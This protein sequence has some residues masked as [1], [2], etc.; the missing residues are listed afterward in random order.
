[1]S[2]RKPMCAD[3]WAI[4]PTPLMLSHGNDYHTCSA[5]GEKADAPDKDVSSVS[6]LGRPDSPIIPTIDSILDELMQYS[7]DYGAKKIPM[8]ENPPIIKARQAKAQL[9][10]I[11]A[12]ERQT[13]MKQAKSRVLRRTE[14]PKDAKNPTRDIVV[15]TGEE[16]ARIIQQDIDALQTLIEE[17]PS[18]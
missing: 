14:I 17:T 13:G 3:A 16:C 10:R 18:E 2:K 4:P 12:I 11:Y 5:C 9:Q 15:I 6:T 7:Y 8:S 1:M